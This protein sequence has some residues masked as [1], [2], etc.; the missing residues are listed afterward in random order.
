MEQVPA[1]TP[2]NTLLVGTVVAP[3][4]IRGQVKMRAITSN[5]D[6][7]IRRVR[8]VYLGP[9]FQP[10]RISRAFEHKPGFLVLSL[11]GVTTRE[12]AEGLRDSDVAILAGAAPPLAADEYFLHDLPGLRVETENGEL[13]GTVR[14][15][16]ETGAN[17]VIV[18]AREGAPEALIP[19]VRDIVAELNI[20]AGRIV[21]RPLPGL[22]DNAER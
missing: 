1:P 6:H 2:D 12:Q 20:P 15:Y 14:D 13:I 4:G 22:L 11:D 7:F 8:D 10:Y 5:I 21:I 3:F 17:E 16:I 18:V 19:L 9:K